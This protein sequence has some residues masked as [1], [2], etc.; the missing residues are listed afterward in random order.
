M[1]CVIDGKTCR[2]YNAEL[3]SCNYTSG[4]ITPTISKSGNRSEFQ[5]VRATQTAGTLS[6]KFVVKAENL[7][8]LHDCINRL[9]EAL[10]GQSVVEN[11]GLLY[12]TALKT[13]KES[14]LITAVCRI[15]EYQFVATKHTRLESTSSKTV[16]CKSTV[17]HTDCRVT[18]VS[19]KTTSRYNVGCVTFL[20][21]KKG[22][23]LVVDG[24][25]NQILRNGEH[26]AST[27]EF[28]Q[29]IMLAPGENT[30]TC[31]DTP[32]IEYYPTF[33]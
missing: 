20:S 13:A 24:L 3:L 9:T 5:Y 11:N 10:S 30:I 18:V 33:I 26:S 4:N 31:D 22:D 6:L 32:M 29:L 1:D 17:A 16:Y 15:M 14:E 2:L 8:M 27:A 25:K 12:K 21:V 19:S 7:T 28:T 23:V